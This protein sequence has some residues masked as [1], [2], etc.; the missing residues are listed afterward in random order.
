ME[1]PQQAPQYEIEFGEELLKVYKEICAKARAMMDRVVEQAPLEFQVE[2]ARISRKELTD[3]ENNIY[4]LF[5]D[6]LTSKFEEVVKREL[7]KTQK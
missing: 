3:Y 6:D 7:A 4:N 1:K 5:S 2:L